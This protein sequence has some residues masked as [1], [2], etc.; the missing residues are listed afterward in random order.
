MTK[1][2]FEKSKIITETKKAA[3]IKMP[4]LYKLW[5]P[6]SLIKRKMWFLEAFLPSDM[7]FKLFTQNSELICTNKEVWGA[8]N[9]PDFA[10]RHHEEEKII[11]HKPKKMTPKKAQV[12][13][14]LKR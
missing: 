12:D 5:L 10:I 9:D 2:I 3:L 1:I 7:K 11:Y 6:K 13:D 4:S 8:F 14:S